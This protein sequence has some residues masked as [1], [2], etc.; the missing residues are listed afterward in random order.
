MFLY[1]RFFNIWHGKIH[2]SGGCYQMIS[3]DV[4]FLLGV[5]SL[6]DVKHNKNKLFIRN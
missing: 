2:Y 1:T 4:I 3:A 5:F 6:F